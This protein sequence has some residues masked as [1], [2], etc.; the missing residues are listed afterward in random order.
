MVEPHPDAIELLLAESST[1]ARE[2][3]R[4]VATFARLLASDARGD[5]ARRVRVDLGRATDELEC[6]ARR[7]RLAAVQDLLRFFLA[8]CID[9]ESF[10]WCG[11]PGQSYAEA[12]AR[13]LLE[14]EG[15]SPP[16]LPRPGEPPL[17]V[18]R[19]LLEVA[20]ASGMDPP[21]LDLWRARWTRAAEDARSAEPAFRALLDS[22]APGAPGV[23]RAEALAGA[24]ECALDAGHVR[25]AREL[26]EAHGPGAPVTPRLARL[27]SWCAVVSG[28][29]PPVTDGAGV[30]G[31]PGTP[32]T[33]GALGAQ[34]RMP[35]PR[36][37]EELRE[38]FPEWSARLAGRPA[39]AA[40]VP[41]ALRRPTSRADLGASVFAVFAFDG[42]A[43]AEPLRVD[44]APAL[45]ARRADWLAR[46][47]RAWSVPGE[48]EHEVVANARPVKRYQR[49][50]GGEQAT[51]PPL[52]GALD[53]GARA[54]AVAPVLDAGE[55]VGWL[56]VEWPHRLAPGSERLARLAGT[57]RAALVER[58]RGERP[59]PGVAAGA[60]SPWERRDHPLAE[61]FED[62][63]REL[64]FKSSHRR[65][66]GFDLA[67]GETSF[68]VDGGA[69][70]AW[71]GD[72]G[73][74]GRAL[75]RAVA[76]SGIV[77]F[78]EPDVR[79]SVHAEA[80]SGLVIPATW[81]GRAL[82]LLALESSR[83]RDF[84][85]FDAERVREHASAVA[86]RARVAQFRAWYVERYGRDLYFGFAWPGSSGEARRWGAAARSL[87]PVVL[88][89]PAGV[90][91]RVLGRWLAWERD[92]RAPGPRTLGP[93]V[94]PGALRRALEAPEPATLLALREPL[95]P[96]TQARWIE[97]LDERAEAPRRW[98]VLLRDS[99]A[100]C[101]ERGLLGPDLAARLDRVQISLAPLADRREEIPGMLDFFA[102]RVAREEG[103]E[104]P[105]FTDDA[106]ALLW[107]QPWE[108]NV[109]AL[110]NLVYKLVLLGGGGE[111]DA[112]AVTD[113]ARGFGIELVPRIPSR[114]PRERD[115]V[116]ALRSTRRRR[117]R[118]NKTRAAAYLGWD[119]DTLV[120]RM[121][122]A[123]LVEEELE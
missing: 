97:L 109:R 73:G 15:A 33:P 7:A 56:H 6:H 44:L 85:S 10:A 52:R 77:A 62:W 17:E 39:S 108:G 49:P 91:K 41:T 11:A 13:L 68:V 48:P 54:L 83:R 27:A 119:P 8:A 37:L 57:W 95:S 63:A 12:W 67:G 71:S 114:H 20:E 118:V 26:L 69:G 113:L 32:G 64:A 60:E 38:A 14:D 47:D 46:R 121:R 112:A 51:P 61:V 45:E 66:F 103:V 117:G 65:W 102:R 72:P 58:A 100:A 111:L 50:G 74:G 24:V 28:E 96:R 75:R 90:G 79:L 101:V 86:L 93:L 84:R 19:R 36:P 1:A 9:R 3:A 35:L 2:R 89:G 87:A 21:R 31:T 107:R 88:C 80:A 104:E 59:S 106:V 105:S 78:E 34:A 120:T 30:P 42:R 29:D 43:C 55:V 4:R 99:L 76:S 53:P 16:E 116:A 23:L 123:G 98:I 25:R 82:A 115:L 40:A 94:S 70:L 122:E 92:E 110:E 81:N 22:G 5:G 18:A